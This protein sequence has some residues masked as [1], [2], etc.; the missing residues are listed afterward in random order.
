[1]NWRMAAA[2]VA[3]GAVTACAQPPAE[4]VGDAAAAARG[5]ELARSQERAGD[6]AAALASYKR[7]K[8]EHDRILVHEAAAA[9]WRLGRNMVGGAAVLLALIAFGV[10]RRR[11]EAERIAERV[12]VTDPL[13][14]L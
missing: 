12:S 9:R 4:G 7:F 2:C 8:E 5:E 3:L 14:G 6:Y 1:M 13:T 11:V 10:Y